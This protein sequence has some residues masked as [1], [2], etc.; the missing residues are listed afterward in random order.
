MLGKEHLATPASINSLAIVLDAQGKYKAAERLYRRELN[1]S[2]KTLGKEDPYMLG[3]VNN[4]GVV[5]VSQGNYNEAEKLYR[6]ALSAREK[7]L[8]QS[9]LIYL[10]PFPT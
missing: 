9:I 6:R 3:S 1:A 4:L 10:A 8:G 5:L 2:E 7:I